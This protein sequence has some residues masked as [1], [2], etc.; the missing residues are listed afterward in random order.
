M[1]G[2]PLASVCAEYAYSHRTVLL[3]PL[4]GKWLVFRSVGIRLFPVGIRQF[5]LPRSTADQIFNIKSED[6][7]V[8]EL[9]VTGVVAIASLGKPASRW[10]S[11]SRPGYFTALRVFAILPKVT[12]VE[13]RISRW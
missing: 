3:L 9:G 7:L 12:K 13:M 8:R 10:R 4:V 11:P 6:A 1:F 5:F 2:L